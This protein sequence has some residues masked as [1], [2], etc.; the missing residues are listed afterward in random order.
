MN[1][2]VFHRGAQYG[3]DIS[4]SE[5]IKGGPY[6][7]IYSLVVI[8]VMMLAA[9]VVTKD[10]DED[11]VLTKPARKRRGAGYVSHGRG[12]SLATTAGTSP[13]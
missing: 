12:E 1:Q 7:G 9:I 10:P 13:K 3:S 8:I 4:E 11:S 6:V 5:S 2:A